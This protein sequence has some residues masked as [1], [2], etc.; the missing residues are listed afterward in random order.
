MPPPEQSSEAPRG[1]VASLADLVGW[2]PFQIVPKPDDILVHWIDLHDSG[3]A[4]PF[5]AQTVEKRLTDPARQV[6]TTPITALQEVAGLAESRPPGAFVFHCARAGS[7]LLANAFRALPGNI[8]LAEPPPFNQLMGAPHRYQ[9]AGPWPG[10]LRD[11]L[12]CLSQPRRPGDRRSIVKFNSL[13]TLEGTRLAKVFPQVPCLFLYRHP[14]EVMVSALKAPPIW[15]KL[16]QDPDGAARRLA[17]PP[18]SLRDI[19]PED[20]AG[21]ALKRIFETA[22]DQTH[23]LFLNYED[24]TAENLPAIAAALGLPLEAASEA[25]LQAVFGRDAK[26][27]DPAAFTADAAQKRA[28]AGPAVQAACAAH[29]AASF[30]ALE[31][32]RL[33]F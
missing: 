23:W 6:I 30:Q 16:Q 21:L 19:P 28:A 27:L 13:T 9:A 2:T 26:S 1:K 11:L 17:L 33:R 25:R 22:L 31:A 10:W 8:V 29:L 7:T 4:E 32:R 15:L 14:L 5:F 12:V 24:L 3:F 20:F 18:K